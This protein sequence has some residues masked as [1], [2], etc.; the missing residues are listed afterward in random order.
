MTA[1]EATLQRILGHLERI[2]GKLDEHINSHLPGHQPMQLQDAHTVQL[3]VS[4]VRAIH[5]H[6]QRSLRGS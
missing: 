6:R 3:P 5:N 1:I 2:E 4:P